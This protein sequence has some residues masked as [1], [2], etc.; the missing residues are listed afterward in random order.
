MNEVKKAK[1]VDEVA[2]W[3]QH[4]INQKLI[5]E[6]LQEWDRGKVSGIFFGDFVKAY[7]SQRWGKMVRGN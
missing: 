1:T 4:E 5:G 3:N 6:A 7:V 2:V